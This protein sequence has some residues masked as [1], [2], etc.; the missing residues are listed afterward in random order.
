MSLPDDRLPDGVAPLRVGFA[1]VGHWHAHFFYAEL[2]LHPGVELVGAADS[3]PVVA[4]REAER[5]RC[6]PFSSTAELL[7]RAAPDVVFAFGTHLEMGDVASALIDAGVPF[8]IEKPSGISAVVVADLADRAERA[9]L[10]ADLPLVYRMSPW[11]QHARAAAK[12]H[13]GPHIEH[14]HFRLMSGPPDRYASAGAEWNLDP[15]QSGGGCTVNL[16]VHLIDLFCYLVDEPVE[17]R[18]AT[19]S[20]SSYGL[21]VE[22]YSLLVL[23]SAS[24]SIATIETG[25]TFPKYG[26]LD[27][28]CAVRTATHWY[29]V[30]PSETRTISI[31]T[32]DTIHVVGPTTNVAF[33]GRFA[34]DVVDRVRT[35]A[36]P[37]ADLRA[38]SHTLA[39]VETAYA[40]A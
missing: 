22:D 32:N 2:A 30:S 24:G 9:G 21:A 26:E 10:Y 13:D 3:D 5:L 15:E 31:A 19:T 40:V 7:D 16:G 27:F 4:S 29:S 39:L 18:S 1:G 33:Y 17:V 36:S 34:R 8:A 14:A 28:S 38:M 11:V 12:T 35:G 37:L 6:Q 20:T 25:Y 23:Q